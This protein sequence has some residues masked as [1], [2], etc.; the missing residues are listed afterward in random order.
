MARTGVPHDSGS[1]T[2]FERF[3][4]YSFPEADARAT[5]ANGQPPSQHPHEETHAVAPEEN[6]VSS[7]E[8]DEV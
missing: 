8:H 2:E 3:Y 5:N 6:S 7:D 4:Q 1:P